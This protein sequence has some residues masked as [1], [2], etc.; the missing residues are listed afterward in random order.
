MWD[1][2]HI[3]EWFISLKWA[4]YR[5]RRCVMRNRNNVKEKKTIVST[6]C[7]HYWVIEAADGPISNG[8][9]KICGEKRKFYN[10]W[11]GSGYMGKDAQIF[12]LP[13]MLDDDE[14]DH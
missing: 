11:L 3:Q 8:V 1:K 7:R 5:E 12:D 2:S 4:S 14:E 10:S 6:D 9:C 13:N